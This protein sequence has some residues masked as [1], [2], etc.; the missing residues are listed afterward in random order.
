[1]AWHLLNGAAVVKDLSPYQLI[2]KKSRVKV[3]RLLQET[4]RLHPFS[5]QTSTS[6]LHLFLPNTL[7]LSLLDETIA[8]SLHSCKPRYIH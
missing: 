5:T 7:S 4:V 2:K 8:G 1:M 6:K 3:I